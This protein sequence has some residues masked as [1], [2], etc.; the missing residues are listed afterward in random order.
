MT[1]PQMPPGLDSPAASGAGG[2]RDSVSSAQRIREIIL[3]WIFA[4]LVTAAWHVNKMTLKQYVLHRFTWTT[5]DILW[6]SPLGNLLVLAVPAA[7]LVLLALVAPRLVPR[8]VATFVPVFLAALGMVIIVPGL[9]NYAIWVLAFGIALQAARVVGGPN[10]DRWLARIKLVTVALGALFIIVGTTARFWRNTAEWRWRRTAATPATDAPNVLILILDTIRAESM[11]LYGYS[12]ATTPVID[13][14]ASSA[15]VFNYAFATSGWTLPS[16]CSFFTGRF[17]NSTS[18]GWE[19]A[20]DNTPRTVAEIF[21][22]RG[23]RTAG[24]AANLFYATHESGLARGFTRWEDFK[25]SFKQVVAS[26]TLAQTGMLRNLFWDP[27]GDG[28][29]TGFKTMTIKGDPKPEVDRRSAEDVAGAFLGW[30]GTDEQRPFFAYLNFF[31]AHE[32][33]EPPHA[34][35]SKFV[36]DS[37]RV[38]DRYDGG[39][40]YIDQQIGRVLDDLRRRGVLDRTLVMIVGD[41]GEQFGEHYVTTH[42]NSLYIQLLRVP[43]V[44]RLPGKI[45]SGVR[46]NRSVT[47]RDLPRTVLELAGIDDTKGIFGASL[48]PAITDSAHSTSVILAE[49]ERTPKWTIVPTGPGPMSAFM[50]QQYHYIRGFTGKEWLF[51]YR[52]DPGELHDLAPESRSK[53]VLEQLR[54]RLREH[55]KGERAGAPAP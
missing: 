41:H 51:D 40:A 29:L 7:L 8:S 49:T 4:S 14:L 44:M 55:G 43:L 27:T 30:L 52:A 15:T 36:A 26:S 33:Y 13:S 5:R 19:T 18:C 6:M 28:R 25:V 3:L 32:P 39:I 17:P 42:G 34:W 47:L 48:L 22:G 20:L 21:R 53:A 50:D 37:P 54:T 12:R 31:D 23:Y 9:A 2:V 38:K 45:P 35:R 24:F 10:G 16:H 1:N 11:S 46:V